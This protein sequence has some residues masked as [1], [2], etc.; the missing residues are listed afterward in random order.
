[1]YESRVGVLS[2]VCIF[3]DKMRILSR[4]ASF[5]W[6]LIT[7][8]SGFG[9][10]VWDGPSSVHQAPKLDGD[11]RPR[12]AGRR[13]GEAARRTAGRAGGSRGLSQP[14]HGR[15]SCCKRG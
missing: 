7:T 14:T 9:D 8:F 3:L 1:M 10:F 4:S 12:S 6:L 15:V 11:Q 2:F 5:R 13:P